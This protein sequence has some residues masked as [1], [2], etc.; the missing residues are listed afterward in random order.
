MEVGQIVYGTKGVVLE[1]VQKDE[2]RRR[3][4][5]Q[6]LQRATGTAILI[7]PSS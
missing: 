6:L 7:E 5:Q 3:V 1:G 4:A 2:Q